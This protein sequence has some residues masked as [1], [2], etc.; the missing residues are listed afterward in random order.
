MRVA[1]WILT[2]SG[3]A[4]QLVGVALVFYDIADDR[5]QALRVLTERGTPGSEAKDA[6]FVAS[7]GAGGYELQQ[8]VADLVALRNWMSAR[9][10]GGI[11]RREWGASLILAGIVV[12]AAASI[13]TLTD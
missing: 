6:L 11:G 13:L 9:L 12:A 8:A 4:L 10:R 3:A 5:R 1:E 7:V 2:V